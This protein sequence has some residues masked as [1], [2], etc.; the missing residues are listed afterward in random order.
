MEEKED[1]STAPNTQSDFLSFLWPWSQPESS[2]TVPL[3]PVAKA[4]P[5]VQTDRVFTLVGSISY[6]FTADVNHAEMS[7]MEDSYKSRYKG[8]AF[9]KQRRHNGDGDGDGHGDGEEDATSRQYGD[10]SLLALLEV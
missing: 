3:S 9:R 5:D 4:V 8:A 2:M 10:D 7:M 1:S 6:D